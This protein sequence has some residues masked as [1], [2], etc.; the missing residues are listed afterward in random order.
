[1]V[2]LTFSRGSTSTRC[3]VSKVLCSMVRVVFD[4]CWPQRGRLQPYAEASAGFARTDVE[5]NAKLEFRSD[6]GFTS[7]FPLRL[8]DLLFVAEDEK[9]RRAIR[10]VEQDIST[11]FLLAFGGGLTVA[12]AQPLSLDV[13]YRYN[14]IFGDAI[15]TNLHQL[16]GGV[17]VV[18]TSRPA[19]RR[20]TVKLTKT[21]LTAPQDDGLASC[22]EPGMLGTDQPD[23][24]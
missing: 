18:P 19:A 11:D 20:G 14:R 13:G 7:D 6:L 21:G 2:L 23:S 24:A 8:D 12:V 16:Y 5:F 4:S 17:N 10:A 1:M 3:S 15:A 9:E 22:C